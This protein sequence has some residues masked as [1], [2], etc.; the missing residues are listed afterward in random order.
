[1]KNRGLREFIIVFIAL[2]II[3]L[4]IIPLIFNFISDTEQAGL[5]FF[6]S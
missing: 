3:V 6:V 2:I 4:V 5:Q 1:M